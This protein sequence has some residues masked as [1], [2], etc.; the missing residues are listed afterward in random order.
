MSYSQSRKSVVMGQ[1]LSKLSCCRRRHRGVA[2]RSSAI[3]LP[4]PPLPKSEDESS[5]VG[6]APR[7]RVISPQAPPT[8]HSGHQPTR[9]GSLSAEKKRSESALAPTAAL[10][11]SSLGSGWSGAGVCVRACV[12]ACMCVCDAL[13]VLNTGNGAEIEGLHYMSLYSLM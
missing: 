9:S 8:P 11:L 2:G 5:Y 6:A 4:L 13:C 7:C 12:R 3:H 1:K 10:S